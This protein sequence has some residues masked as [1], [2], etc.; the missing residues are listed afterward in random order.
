MPHIHDKIDFTVDVFVV[1][2]NKVLIRKHEKYHKWLSVGGHIE[3][4]ENPNQAAI[5]EVKEE[6]GLD[7][8]LYNPH[9]TPTHEQEGYTEL[10]PPLYLNIHTISDS[11]QHMSHVYF[12]QATSDR[13][14]PQT[15]HEK[16]AECIWLTREEL[17]KHPEIDERIKFYAQ[18]AL[19]VFGL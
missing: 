10:I 5:R 8:T 4:D 7:V 6:V 18:E 19:K 14:S 12:A 11:H 16:D 3:L 9:P 13:I 2:Q 15:D 1:F 17:R